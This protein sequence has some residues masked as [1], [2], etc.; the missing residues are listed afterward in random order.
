MFSTCQAPM[1]HKKSGR[2]PRAHGAGDRQRSDG[3]HPGATARVTS[4]WV[5]ANRVRTHA[6]AAEM[7]RS[8]RCAAAQGI[9]RAVA[10]TNAAERSRAASCC[11]RGA[12]LVAGVTYTRRVESNHGRFRLTIASIAGW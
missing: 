6:V 5:N 4:L 12:T 3:P 9:K 10:G 7:R 2:T 1:S 11:H 8:G